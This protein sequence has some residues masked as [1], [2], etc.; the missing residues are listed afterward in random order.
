MK[1]LRI[2]FCILACLCVAAAVPVGIFF[3]LGYVFIP[4]AAA[5]L[6]AVLMAVAKGRSEAAPREGSD[7]MDP[8]DPPSSGDPKD[9][10][11]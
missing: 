7:F 1:I 6:F 4:V 5:G 3:D 9:G 2:V 11:Q 8:K 10:E